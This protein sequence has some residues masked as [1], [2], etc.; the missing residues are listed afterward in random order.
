MRRVPATKLPQRKSVM[1]DL[2]RKEEMGSTFNSFFP[3]R[4]TE[5]THRLV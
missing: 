5:L 4:W 1:C 3:E 2:A